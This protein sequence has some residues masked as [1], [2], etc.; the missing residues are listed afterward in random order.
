MAQTSTSAYDHHASTRAQTALD[1][2][3]VH[4]T[5]AICCSRM[6]VVQVGDCLTVFN[7]FLLEKD[8]KGV[9][10]KESTIHATRNADFT[11][12]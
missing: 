4:A 10:W 1:H 3:P 9:V 6:D 2:T 12:K 5:L 8:H 7:G 11:F